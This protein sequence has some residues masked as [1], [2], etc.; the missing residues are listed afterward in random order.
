MAY[1]RLVAVGLAAAVAL[2]G[3]AVAD[4]SDSIE[5]RKISDVV[6]NSC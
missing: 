4:R 1:Q 3:R 5:T 2:E 6:P